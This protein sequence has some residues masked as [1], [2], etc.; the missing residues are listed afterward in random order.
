[1]CR[2]ARR[3]QNRH[4]SIAAVTSAPSDDT[5]AKSRGDRPR[6]VLRQQA[7]W[8]TFLVITAANWALMRAFA[9]GPS[10]VSIPYTLFK[11]QVQADNVAEVTSQGD[12][13]QGTF[14]KELTY[15]PEGP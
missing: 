8:L 12:A 7:W 15:P 11:A 10:L 14:K 2:P 4:A 5:V 3:R 9:P 6:R 13:I 1:M